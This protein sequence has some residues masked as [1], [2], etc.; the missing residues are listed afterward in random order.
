[1][2][3]KDGPTVVLTI[4]FRGLDVDFVAL[5]CVVAMCILLMLSTRAADILNTV[6]TGAQMVVILVLII[7]GFV[8][9]NPANMTPFA[10]N[11]VRGIFN[12]ASFVFFSFIGFDAVATLSEETKKPERDM[13]V[14][15]VGC[16]SFV[17]VVY[18]IM[19]L[20][21][22]MMVPYASLDESAAFAVAFE[23]AGFV[24]GRYLVSIGA[25][26]GTVTGVLVGIMGVARLMCCLCRS[27]I[28][29]PVFGR[30]NAKR[31]TPMWATA[32]TSLFVAP[33]ALLTDLPAL[34]DMCSAAAL[35]AFGVVA[36]A[37]LFKRWM[38]RKATSASAARAIGQVV[39][40]GEKEGGETKA[41]WAEGE[42]GALGAAVSAASDSRQGKRAA[43]V[44]ALICLLSTGFAI[45]WG[46]TAASDG[47]GWISIVVLAAATYSVAIYGACTLKKLDKCVFEA[48]LFPFLPV[49]SL[50]MNCFLMAS[51]SGKAY[52]QLSIFWVIMIAIYLLY[53][54]HA[55][56]IF[57]ALQQRGCAAATTAAG[58]VTGSVQASRMGSVVAHRE[59]ATVRGRA[60]AGVSILP[61]EYDF[62]PLE[63]DE[64]EGARAAA[65][66]A[67]SR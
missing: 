57:D 67:A 44:I 5:A 27:H 61:P 65:A 3:P 14:G 33:F 30:V 16:I 49:T 64:E 23:Q 66:P 59:S 62:V 32:L 19:S 17:T 48:P 2:S 51:L 13:P 42:G 4:P 56:T 11:G 8:K 36:I 25:V 21:L 60:G 6:C 24:W 9:A 47:L 35:A 20:V 22:V 29:M 10:P 52:W 31:G 41:A 26:L 39:D 12:G 43:V 38:P 46:L 34:I 18:I 55:A 40:D 58:T 15:V 54:I 7:S 50:L 45:A 37:H 1:V 28:G 63:E 53:S